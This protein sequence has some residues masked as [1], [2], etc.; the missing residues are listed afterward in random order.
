[1][2][3]NPFSKN[4]VTYTVL[5][6]VG[7]GDAVA[8]RRRFSDF[9]K[10]QKS[11]VERFGVTGMLIPSLPPKKGWGTSPE[12]VAERVCAL[13]LFADA[14]D[15]NPFLSSDALWLHF[16][17]PGG[18]MDKPDETPSLSTG[19]KRALEEAAKQKAATIEIERKRVESIKRKQQQE[20]VRIS[21]SRRV[22][23][24]SLPQYDSCPSEK[25]LGGLW[26]KFE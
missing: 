23:V 21:A 12:V 8:V 10:L 26:S 4:F 18:D 19:E 7:N 24:P 6:T 11:F 17:T 25:A 3:N 9:E 13:T 2:N 14:V 15:R 16:L 1:M 5:V 22:A 20:I